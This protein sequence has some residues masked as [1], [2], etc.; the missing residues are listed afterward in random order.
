MLLLNNLVHG[1]NLIKGLLRGMSFLGSS[2]FLNLCV[3]K[4]RHRL[5][6]HCAAEGRQCLNIYAV[7]QNQYNKIYEGVQVSQMPNSGEEY[8]ICQ[9]KR[10]KV[11]RVKQKIC[12]L[13]FV[14][15]NFNCHTMPPPTLYLEDFCSCAISNRHTSFHD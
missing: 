14:E 8:A 15:R 13:S 7:Y 5:I 11:S 9:V 6:Q 12:L 3:C 10:S 2:F 1:F 4:R